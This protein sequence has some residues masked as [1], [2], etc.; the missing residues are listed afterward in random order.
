M[1]AD[2]QVLNDEKPKYVNLLLLSTF[3]VF[4]NVVSLGSTLSS[5]TVSVTFFGHR[6]CLD[7]SEFPSARVVSTNPSHIRLK[8]ISYQLNTQRT[9]RTDELH[10]NKPINVFAQ[11]PG[12]DL[13]ER[14]VN[15]HSPTSLKLT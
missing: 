2:Y 14:F 10:P 5:T 1:L 3:P 7:A 11:K 15:L 9:S 6:D 12:R 4:R 8:R 13:Y